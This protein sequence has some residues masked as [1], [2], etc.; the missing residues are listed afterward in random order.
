MISSRNRTALAVIAI[1]FATGVSAT[2]LETEEQRLGYLIGM[3]IGRSLQGQGAEVDLD[4]MFDAIRTLYEGGQPLMTPEQAQ[5]VRE[6]YMAKRQAAATAEQNAL[7]TKNLAE[8][9]E[10]LAANAGK[11]GV[12]VTESGLQ[13]Q[14]LERG[15]GAQPSAT[16]TVTV[17]Y[18][19]TLLDGTEFDSSYSRNEP[20]SFA[21]NRVIPGWTEGLQLMNVGSKYQFFIKPELGYGEAG[22]GSIPPNSTLIFEVELLGIGEDAD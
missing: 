22:G 7:A 11:E 9:R 1:L 16:D 6:N 5:S 15:D 18:R 21:L 17:H 20:I 10:F 8:S 13:Y 3:D 14:V 19:G 4:A 12:M 2:E